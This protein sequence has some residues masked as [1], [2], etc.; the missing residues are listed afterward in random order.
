MWGDDET[1]SII[2]LKFQILGKFLS[3]YDILTLKFVTKCY[4]KRLDEAIC[5]LGSE[6]FT[7]N[8]YRVFHSQNLASLATNGIILGAY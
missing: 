1:S 4:L 2:V 6:D 8:N 3:L 7:E 5:R